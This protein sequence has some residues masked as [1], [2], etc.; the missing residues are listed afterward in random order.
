MS[1]ATLDEREDGRAV[2]VTAGPEWI[3]DRHVL[4]TLLLE[5]YAAK[6]AALRVDRETALALLS[7]ALNLDRC[8]VAA[9]NGAAIGV[10]GLVEGRSHALQFPFAL[11]RRHFGVLRCVAYS[12]L[13]GLRS[14]P[15]TGELFVEAFAV[16]P[17]ERN[18]GIGTRLLRHAEAHAI[19]KG[20]QSIGLEVTDSNHAAIRL[21]SRLAYGI[22]K[23]RR[24]PSVTRRAGFS[25]S[26]RMRKRVQAPPCPGD[27][28][29]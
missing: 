13:M 27:S 24:F 12:L 4:A 25:G 19:E 26:H 5:G 6:A 15:D 23:T 14:R 29:S 21:Y 11:L 18:R 8:L 3:A 1:Q 7:G 22:V 17:R 16:S 2:V 28:T 10:I 20:Y 9:R